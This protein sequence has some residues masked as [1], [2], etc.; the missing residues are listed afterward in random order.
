MCIVVCAHR[1][2]IVF[3]RQA[4]FAFVAAAQVPAGF[5]VNLEHTVLYQ[6]RVGN[7][8]ACLINQNRTVFKQNLCVKEILD[9]FLGSV[10]VIRRAAHVEIV[11]VRFRV[12]CFRGAHKFN[13]H[14][15][16]AFIMPE[17]NGAVIQHDLFPR[18]VVLLNIHI[19]RFAFI[20]IRRRAA[21][22]IGYKTVCIICRC[23]AK[24]SAGVIAAKHSFVF[25]V[26]FTIA[27]SVR[28]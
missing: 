22:G 23:A 1:R 8:R 3:V 7:R 6:K 26:E 2:I 11:V 12:S 19:R 9:I 28:L 24:C 27:F 5:N 10:N 18:T 4:V 15:D 20:C 13:R 14:T 16:I 25:P 17:V 21:C